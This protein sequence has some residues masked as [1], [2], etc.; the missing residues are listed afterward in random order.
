MEIVDPIATSRWS[1]LKMA[2][3][4]ATS[5]ALPRWVSRARLDRMKAFA[6][7]MGDA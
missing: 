5:F 1:L 3:L 6:E 7:E 4:A 2:G